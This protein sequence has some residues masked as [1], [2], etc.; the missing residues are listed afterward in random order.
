MNAERISLGW[1]FLGCLSA[2]DFC[3]GL[4]AWQLTPISRRRRSSA[5]QSEALGAATG[6]SVAKV[7]DFL[8]SRPS[9]TARKGRFLTCSLA[10]APSIAYFPSF[11]CY[12]FSALQWHRSNTFSPW[13][14]WGAC[15]WTK[16]TGRAADAR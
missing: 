13:F 7:A 9:E 15:V 16:P 14:L 1:K 2:K 5:N 3:Q 6:Q 12:P 11:R 8:Q 10:D 4:V